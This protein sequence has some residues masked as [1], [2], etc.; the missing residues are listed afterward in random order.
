M[1]QQLTHIELERLSYVEPEEFVEVFMSRRARDSGQPEKQK[2]RAQAV[3]FFIDV[4]QECFNIGNFTPS[5]P[6]SEDLAA[7]LLRPTHLSLQGEKALSGMSMAPVSRLRRTW[8]RVNTDKFNILEVSLY[9]MCAVTRERREE[10]GEE[11]EI[12]DRRRG[13]RGREEGK[14]RDETGGEERE[15]ER[16]EERHEK[17]RE[18]E[19]R[20]KGERGREEEAGEEKGKEGEEEER[21]GREKR[22]GEEDMRQEER[23]RAGERDE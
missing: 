18:G 17:E 20:R 14:R 13:R 9:S 15:K 7:D 11:E 1:A 19:Q 2:Q 5:W 16:D 8:S 10:G 3:N 12:C 6:S 4:A 22:E 23:K 21:G